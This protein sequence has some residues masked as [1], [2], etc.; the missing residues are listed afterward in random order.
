MT[1]TA[2]KRLTCSFNPQYFRGPAIRS[3]VSIFSQRKPGRPAQ[4][5]PFYRYP[6]NKLLIDNLQIPVIIVQN[7]LDVT[8]R[9]VIR[10]FRQYPDL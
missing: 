7:T 9:I 2:I 3:C 1:D 5:Y 10:S 6:E 4:G 8:E